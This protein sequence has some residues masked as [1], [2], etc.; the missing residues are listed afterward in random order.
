M[1]LAIINFSSSGMFHY[2]ACLVNELTRRAD[3]ELLFL[4]S[5]FNN[6][7]LL[8]KRPNLHLI[9]Q[10]TP[11]NVLGFFKWLAAPAE[12]R[13]LYQS[14]ARFRPDVIH[15]T[16]AHA[17]CVPH[18]W[19]LA[20]YP[21]LLTQHDPAPHSGDVYRLPSYFIHRTQQR[22]AKRIVVHGQ[23]LKDVLLSRRGVPPNK[24]SI[25]PHGDYSFYLRWRNSA[26][27]PIQNSVLFFGR[28]VDYKGLDVLLES[29]IG[30]ERGGLPVT[31]LLAGEG[32]LAKYQPLL[33]QLPHK[34]IDNRI[35]PEAEVLRYFD[36]STLVAL[37]YREASQ[38]GIVSIA[39]P[40]G[41]PIVASR[42]GALPEILK[43]GENAWL[44]E[45]NDPAELAGA[46]KRLL[47]DPVLRARL[48][49]AGI[50]TV[51]KKIAWRLTAAQYLKL[52]LELKKR[53]DTTA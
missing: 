6:L 43:H 17:F 5:A 9:A 50:V 21:V 51:D 31:L 10:A 19:W 20:R 4:T 26:V 16:D 12:Q 35:I 40:A 29:L 2:A 42:V 13:R 11:H 49:A 48:A 27:T 37:P 36:L 28:I 47:H 7:E 18:Q 38:S 34:I 23:Y 8:E 44:V 39:L 46:I 32:S 14:V 52:Y 25:I 3:L 15:L 1:R 53:E 41:T 22:L 24:I 45:P 30:L 33:A